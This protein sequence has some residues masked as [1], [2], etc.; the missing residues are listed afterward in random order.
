MNK[1]VALKSVLLAVVLAACGGPS[2]AEIEATVE[3]RVELATAS[4]VA[5]SPVPLPTYTPVPTPVPEIIIKEVE[6]V[7]EVGVEIVV[8]ATPTPESPSM[9]ASPVAIETI[10]YFFEIAFGAEYDCEGECASVIHK[11][12]NDLRIKVSGEPTPEDL[13]TLQQVIVELNDLLTAISFEIVDSQENV[14]IFFIPISEF[15]S[16]DPDYLPEN[17]GQFQVWISNNVI[18]KARILIA[19][20]GLSQIERSHLIREELTQSLGLMIDSYSYPQSVF[21]QA[22]TETVQYAPI[23][24]A[25]IKLL[26]DPRLDAGMSRFEIEN[27]LASQ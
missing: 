25:L 3:A 18:W 4:L 16:I 20:I 9:A 13:E 26:Y 2:E 12:N 1:L 5:P 6:V 15:E 23:D 24:K 21:Q 27:I 22:W 17:W 19:S 8:T 7:K 10:N 14:E 11:W